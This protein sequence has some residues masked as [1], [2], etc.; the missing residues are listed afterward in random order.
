MS[1]LGRKIYFKEQHMNK[2]WGAVLLV[3][4]LFCGFEAKAQSPYPPS[5]F[6]RVGSQLTL[7]LRQ[8][9]TSTIAGKDAD[10]DWQGEARGANGTAGKLFAFMQNNGT[11][12]FQVAYTGA[13]EFCA[14]DASSVTNPSA[15]SVTYVGSRYFKQGT[16]NN[17]PDNTACRVV[18]NN[19]ASPIVQQPVQPVQQPV[20]PVQPPLLPSA[21]VQL[22]TLTFP[23]RL[24]V[25]QRWEIRL[26]NRAIVY[27]GVLNSLDSARNVYLGT[28]TTDGVG[29]PVVQRKLEVFFAQDTLAIYATDP[30]G[31]TTVCSFAGAATLQNNVLTGT[32]FYRAAGASQF[33]TLTAATDAPCKA[34][35]EPVQQAVQ[36]VQPISPVQPVQP[37]QPISPVQPI[38]PVQTLTATLPAQV[39]DSWR[40]TANGFEAW[41]LNFTSAD[42]NDVVGTSTQ[43]T[44]KGE[45][46][47]TKPTS[48]G[49]IFLFSTG[50]RVFACVIGTSTQPQGASISG[51]LFEIVTVNN[52]DQ[53]KDLNTVC[54]VTLTARGGGSNLAV[55]PVQT[56]TATFPPKVGQTWTV[57]IEGLSPWVVLFKDLDKNNEPS[58]TGLQN[59]LARLVIAYVNN[60][61]KIFAM[62]GEN[63]TIYYCAFAANT[64][65]IGATLS[66]GAA[67]QEPQGATQPTAMNKSCTATLTAQQLLLGAAQ[68]LETQGVYGLPN[69][70]KLLPLF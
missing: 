13:S 29:D 12:I 30:Q 36:P 7:E 24:E 58:G 1:R 20:Q 16:Q 23:P 2:S 3:G 55:A 53:T 14:V 6:M 15:S 35:L 63:N 25:G 40:V 11:F 65:P 70:L 66:G 52:Q 43:G 45:A 69:Y 32:V 48:G 56:L 8:N 33:T 42:K 47:G 41:L 54:A 59:G 19:G 22:P 27:R 28:L 34:N 18:V 64:Q 57:T 50:N 4:V 31:G 9:W 60:G 49:Y 38:A 37:V 62:A 5:G 51:A 39:G 46:L 10:G 67:Y 44:I 61:L 17:S 21:Q 26:G 68:H